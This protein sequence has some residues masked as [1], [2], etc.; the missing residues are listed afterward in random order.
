MKRN[1]LFTL[2]LLVSNILFSQT[3]IT[4]L[5]STGYTGAT[6]IA[7]KSV[8]TFAIVNNNSYAI[9]LDSLQTYK[10]ATAPINPDTLTLWYSSIS[11]S[12]APTVATPDWIQIKQVIVSGLTVGYNTVLTNIAFDI[13]AS[14][15]YRFALQSS[16]GLAVS[17]T[18]ATPSTLSS[19]G[20]DLLIG[21]AQIGG[22]NVGYGG[23]FPTPQ[24]AATRWFTGS[25]SF[26]PNSPCTSPP[27]AGAVSASTLFGC[28]NTPFTLSIPNASVGLGLTYQWDSSS[29][30]T[31]WTPIAGATLKTLVKSQVVTAYYRCNITCSGNT[32]TSSSIKIITPNLASGTYTINKAAITSGTNFQS[33]TDA[34][35]FVTC[36]INAPVTFNVA[37][38]SGPYNEQVIIPQIFGASTTNIITIKGNGNTLNNASNSTTNRAGITLY[39]A[40]HIIIDSLK[41]DATTG[42]YGWGV[43]FINKADSNVIK[44]CTINVHDT[45]I[46]TN[47]A[48]IVFNGS[49]SVATVSG[50][51]G[52][53]NT[54]LNNK[55][56]GGYYGVYL[57]GNTADATQNNSNIVKNNTIT[58]AYG[59]GIYAAYQSS[60]LIISGNDISRPTRINSLATTG[61]VSAVAGCFG[62]LI[63]KNRI[64]N[65]F[66]GFL[67]GTTTTYGIYVSTKSKPGNELKVINNII[68]NLNG[69]GP[70]YG[71]YNTGGDSIIFYN[72][73]IILC[74][75]CIITIQI[76]SI[77]SAINFI[78]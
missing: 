2:L 49:G 17:S 23:V 21:N 70:Q 56:N 24:I 48:G 22:A 13:P 28:Y 78:I 51:N 1:L 75:I 10:N 30:G 66:D 64:H 53:Y 73:A 54:I 68:Y 45:S 61:G 38:N 47:F 55:I 36:G 74:C 57:Y 31:T 62:A 50:D 20:V 19:T 5:G 77:I 3:T 7:G 25:I 60:G 37:P 32:A 41:I 29:N 42:T 33:F 46:T 58:N 14:T 16:N 34:I 18:G 65:I 59:V 39:G 11:L 71:L 72:V 6:S 26:S 8:V 4:T 44:N 69:N 76:H 52:S 63:E 43:F 40:D 15:Q 67:N 27:V 9:A 12:G 35:N